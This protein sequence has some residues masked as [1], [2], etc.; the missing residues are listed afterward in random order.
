[1]AMP[2]GTEEVERVL[3]PWLGS[4]FVNAH[5]LAEEVA[6]YLRSYAPY[7]QTL[8]DLRT[9]LESLLLRKLNALTNRSLTVILDNYRSRKLNMSTV[10][11]ITDDLMGIIL[12][13]SRRSQ[14]TSSSST[15][16][17]CAWKAST[18]CA[19]CTRNTLP[20]IQRK[21]SL[22]WSISSRPSTHPR[23]GK[24]GCMT[25][26]ENH[27]K[28]A[29]CH[30]KNDRTRFLLTIYFCASSISFK[31]GSVPSCTG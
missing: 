20:F 29:F 14:P 7:R 10:A 12:T 23:D 4:L 19:Y 31:T 8:E 22:S 21:N 30:S 11:D 13:N 9:E 1:M 17:A 5:P 27:A 28:N 25:D 24:A 2:V 6:D 15:T 18:P 26:V 3:R 16:T